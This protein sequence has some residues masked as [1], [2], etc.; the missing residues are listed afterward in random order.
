M[1]RRLIAPITALVLSFALGG[2]WF[3]PTPLLNADNAS[4][5]PFEGSYRDPDGNDNPVI[6]AS[7]GEG[8]AYTMRQEDVTFDIFFLA[9]DDEWYAVQISSPTA[10]ESTAKPPGEGGLQINPLPND[11]AAYN[12]MRVSNGELRA[13][14]A[15]CTE[16]FGDIEGIEF[17][18][19]GC[20]VTDTDGLIGAVRHY[21][22]L[23]ETGA[24]AAEQFE[25]EV[26][27][28]LPE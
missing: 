6:L 21:A 17:N 23:V 7:T 10:D 18:D 27:E 22:E 4:I 5:I 13:Y 20:L 19:I 16:D 14:N 25:Y 9:V 12:L 24:K 28:P 11:L 15:V 26:L 2:C 8:A 3:S 1:A